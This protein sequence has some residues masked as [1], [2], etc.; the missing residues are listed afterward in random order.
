[1]STTGT[2]CGHGCQGVKLPFAHRCLAH[3]TPS[4]RAFVLKDWALLQRLD[5]TGVTISTDLAAELLS[6]VQAEAI[7]SD[8]NR[9]PWC[10]QLRNAKFAA[11]VNFKGTVFGDGV[12]LGGTVFGDGVS[13][14]QATF[15]ERASFMGARFG[16]AVDFGGTTFGREAWFNAAA[17]GDDAWFGDAH[18]GGGASFHQAVFG[19]RAAFDRIG[20][21]TG[22]AFDEAHFGNDVSFENACLGDGSSFDKASFGD[23]AQLGPLVINGSLSL[24][25]TVFQQAPTI[26]VACGRLDCRKAKF[27]ASG[28]LR[29]RWAEVTLDEVEFERPSIVIAA[30]PFAELTDKERALADRLTDGQPPDPNQPDELVRT[31]R[32]R[33]LSLA[34]CDVSNLTCARLDLRACRFAGAYNLDQLHIDGPTWY[35]RVPGFQRG[36]GWPPLWRWTGRQTLAEEQCWRFTHERS[37]RQRGWWPAPSKWSTDNTATTLSGTRREQAAEIATIYRALRKGLEE[38]KDEPGAADFYYG[39]MEMR[40]NAAQ[41]GVERLILRVYWLVSGYGLR[42]G[43]AITAAVVGLTLFT[44]L[45]VAVGFEPPASSQAASATTSTAGLPTRATASTVGIPTSASKTTTIG[46]PT[47][48]TTSSAGIATT[49]TEPPDTSP[50]GAAAYGARTAIGLPIYPPQPKLTVWGDVLQITLRITVP[51]LLGLAILSI[52]GRVKR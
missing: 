3:A 24:S 1:M 17:F 48:P 51:V 39:E 18:F 5:L 41:P 6:A 43:R 20:F 8:G 13:F 52:R 11:R 12:S 28:T 27:H 30:P 45:M 46:T 7:D 23:W 9:A 29:L 14:G 22:T 21:G 37:T 31:E 33:L 44:V 35:A 36:W 15:G 38:S 4:Q 40:R 32:P 10:P 42:A 2:E 16:D 19:H 47:S 49:T 34:G 26:Q 50:A 25:Q